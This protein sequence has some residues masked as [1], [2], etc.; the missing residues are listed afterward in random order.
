MSPCRVDVREGLGADGF[1]KLLSQDV[2]CQA[3]TDARPCQMG[4]DAGDASIGPLA[5]NLSVKRTQRPDGG[6]PQLDSREIKHRG[7]VL[8]A[9]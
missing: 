4:D 9:H 6:D 7:S 5:A 8:G 3:A 2:T 1:S